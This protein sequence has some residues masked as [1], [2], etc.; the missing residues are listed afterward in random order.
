MWAST[1]RW[2]STPLTSQRAQCSQLY[3]HLHKIAPFLSEYMHPSPVDSEKA[4]VHCWAIS[5]LMS[6]YSTAVPPFPV[7]V[8]LSYPGPGLPVNGE[9]GQ[10]STK[11]IN[12]FL[13]TPVPP[14]L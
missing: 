8:P 6:S 10:K 13:E 14:G 7:P 4:L 9:R 12:R 11:F 1:Q 3:P 2:R 5:S